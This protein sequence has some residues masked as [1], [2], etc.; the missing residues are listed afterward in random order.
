MFKNFFLTAVFFGFS[1]FLFG[2]KPKIQPK[3]KFIESLSLKVDTVVYSSDKNTFE[4]QK[5]NY[6]FFKSNSTHDIAELTLIPSLDTLIQSIILLPSNE[7]SVLDSMKHYSQQYYRAKLRFNDLDNAR[8][9]NLQ[10]LVKLNNG[11]TINQEFKLYPY[12]ETYISYDTEPIDLFLDEEKAIEMPCLNVYNINMDNDFSEIADYEV[13]V[14]QAVNTLKLSVKPKIMNA[15]KIITLKLKTIRPFVNSQNE[16]TFNLP[17]IRVRFNIKPNRVDY[18]NPEKSVVYF[19][20]NFKSSED[21]QFEYNRNMGLRKTYRIEDSQESGGNLIAEIFTQSQLGN[22]NKILCKIR[23]FA[24]HRINEGYLYLKDGDK[25]RFLTNFNIIEKPRI[26]EIAVMHD[27]EDW[28]SNLSVYPGERFELRVKGTGLQQSSLQFEGI[29]NVIRDTTRLSDE[30]AFFI[31]KIP[32]NLPKKKVNI[33][34]NK[35]STQYSVLIKEYQT[36]TDFDFINVNYDGQNNVPL[37]SDLFNKPIFYNGE[38]KDINLLFDPSKIDE[39]GKLF[40]KQFFDIEIKVFNSRNDLLELQNINNLA[41]VPRETSPRSAF[42]DAKDVRFQPISLNDFLVHKTYTFDPFTQ[43]YVTIKHNDLKH[44]S[45]GYTRK[46]KLIVKRK[47]SLDVQVSFPA[48]LL[49]YKFGVKNTSDTKYSNLSGISL[50]F[51]AQLQFYQDNNV[52][53]FKPYSIGA[54]FIAIDAFNFSQSSTNRDLGIVVLGTLTPI[55]RGKLSIPLYLGGGYLINQGNWFVLFG[56]GLR[57][58]F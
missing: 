21:I 8:F 30:V 19:N 2:Q 58:S 26:D 45:N 38:I 53:K 18:L 15:A 14:G 56:P 3:D 1:F 27:G 31:V 51:I 36:P 16:L 39:G 44:G 12:K 5:E 23:T 32:L 22:S 47:Y 34:M 24:L 28:N 10:F 41:M 33:F 48:G 6:L 50:A 37:N 57:F 4:F 17:P 40:G 49:L 29:E 25:T 55:Q 7:F 54:G 35:L 52:N 46:I 43:I 42:Y 9:L 13:K 20:S 11:K